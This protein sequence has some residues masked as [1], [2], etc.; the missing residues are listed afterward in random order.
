MKVKFNKRFMSLIVYLSSNSNNKIVMEFCI[1]FVVNILEYILYK[2]I[3]IFFLDYFTLNIEF[4][5]LTL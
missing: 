3:L 5:L 4:F 1:K 2:K